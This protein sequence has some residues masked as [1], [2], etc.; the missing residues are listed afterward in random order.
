MIFSSVTHPEMGDPPLMETPQKRTL[1]AGV[2][3]HGRTITSSRVLTWHSLTLC[4]FSACAPG[5]DAGVQCVFCRVASS[6]AVDGRECDSMQEIDV[7]RHC[8]H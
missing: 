8:V 1:C 5:H 4:L 3:C 6:E 7:K 2:C